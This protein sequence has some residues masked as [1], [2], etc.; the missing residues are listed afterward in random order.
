MSYTDE[1]RDLILGKAALALLLIII[2]LSGILP[3]RGEMMDET[4][5]SYIELEEEWI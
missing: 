4:D 1:K 5:M 2:I 3:A